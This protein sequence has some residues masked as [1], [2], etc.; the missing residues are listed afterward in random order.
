LT[1]LEVSFIVSSIDA[2]PG[3]QVQT[4]QCVRNPPAGGEARIAW[5]EPDRREL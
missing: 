3:I 5:T 2:L 4:N 1:V